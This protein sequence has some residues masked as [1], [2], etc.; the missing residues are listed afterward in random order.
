MKILI[1]LKEAK[2][3]SKKSSIQKLKDGGVPI[4]EA[5]S[6]NQKN[7]NQGAQFMTLLLKI[8]KRLLEAL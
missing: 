6:K 3:K 2:V 1:K 7:V 5:Q 4:L 8:N